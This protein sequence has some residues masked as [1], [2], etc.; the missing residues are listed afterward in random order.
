[1]SKHEKQVRRTRSKREAARQSMRTQ[2]S[3]IRHRGVAA[4]AAAGALAAGTQAY[5]VPLRFDNPP[6]PNHFDWKWSGGDG[7]RLYMLASAANQTGTSTAPGSFFKSQ[8]A[9]GAGETIGRGTG[10]GAEFEELLRTTINGYPFVV[11]FDS[12][13]LIPPAP[14]IP[15][16]VF[17]GGAYAYTTSY[18]A[19]YYGAPPT[20]L[21]DG[22]PT[23]IGVRFD[24]GAGDHYGWIG[25]IRNGQETDA[26]A[27]AYETEPGVPIRTP[28]P[29]GLALLAFGAVG[30]MARRRRR[31]V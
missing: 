16:V 15:D 28:E 14:P 31:E 19:Y 3:R 8:D 6:G 11:G 24:L 18:G 25:L 13:D 22:V 20:L 21:P 9:Y 23:Y 17:G 30:T 10:G 26:F 5:A 29:G 2:K 1:M 12:G 7:A 27:W 4:L